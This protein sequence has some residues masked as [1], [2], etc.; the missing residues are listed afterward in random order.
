MENTQSKNNIFG[1]VLAG[2]KSTRMG[3]DKGKIIYHNRPHREHIYKM[4]ESLCDKVF[5]SLR[6]DQVEN[7]NS[8][9]NFII[10]QNEY[11]GPFNGI[12]SAHA[13]Y[14]NH[15]WLIVATDLPLLKKSDIVT[16][17]ESRN[18][19][20]IATAFATKE[21]KLPEPLVA[22]WEPSALKKSSE[23]LA[24]G[25]GTCPRKFLINSDIELVYPENDEVLMNANTLEDL[26]LA[27]AKLQ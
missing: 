13:K 27:K 2:G 5:M 18:P 12:L 24:Q 16:L 26:Q 19:N 20:K 11:R 4:L 25:K 8:N 17:I 15:A 1:L 3:T 14:P 6:V 9:F 7:V 21:S 22:I 10:D 23:Y